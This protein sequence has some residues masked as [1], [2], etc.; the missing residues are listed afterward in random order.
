MIKCPI[1]GEENPEGSKF[2]EAC[3]GLLPEVELSPPQPQKLPKKL[4]SKKIPI[5]IGIIIAIMAIIVI[6]VPFFFHSNTGEQDLDGD[7]VPD[8]YD[9]VP[10]KDAKI[11]IS[12]LEFEVLD[13]VDGLIEGKNDAEVYF[14]IYIDG[15][16]IARAPEYGTWDTEIKKPFPCDWDCTP[17]NVMDDMR[18][19]DEWHEIL[20]EMY[21]DD[22]FGKELLDIDGHSNSKE[23]LLWYNIRTGKWIGVVEGKETNGS[24]DEIDDKDCYLKF[25]ITTV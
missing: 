15:K 21:D 16:K 24:D 1:C 13:E 3:G 10:D 18:I 14:E 7:G 2:C 25:D 9:F 4:S 5:T 19:E 22:R 23:L 17:Y 11:M 20:I 12:L 8:K 6:G